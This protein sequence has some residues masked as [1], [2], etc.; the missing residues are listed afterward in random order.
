MVCIP[1]RVRS[2]VS[3]APAIGFSGS[4]SVAPPVCAAIASL[5]PAGVSV[6]VGCAGGVDE[7]FR[8]A[9]PSARVFSVASFGTGRGAFAARSVAVVRAVQSAGGVWVSFP[10]E[11]CPSGLAPS[12]SSSRAFCGAGSGTWASLAFAAGLGLPCLLGAG[13]FEPPVVWGF[14]SLGHGWWFRSAPV[15]AG[16]QLSLF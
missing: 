3:S 1:D 9:F 13:E 10:S 12:A 16:V 11:P 5:V 8:G 6:F 4:R 2:L 15:P 14:V 7:F